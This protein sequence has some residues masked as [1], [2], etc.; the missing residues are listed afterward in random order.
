MLLPDVDFESAGPV[1]VDNV[2]SP[3]IVPLATLPGPAKYRVTATYS[4]NPLHRV[5]WPIVVTQPDLSFYVTPAQTKES[6]LHPRTPLSIVPVGIIDAA[7]AVG[8]HRLGELSHNDE[9][10]FP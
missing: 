1:G 10:P 5:F 3:I 6:A 2:V 4:C 9:R 7:A 8:K